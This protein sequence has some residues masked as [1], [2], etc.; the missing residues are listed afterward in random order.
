MFEMLLIAVE[1]QTTCNRYDGDPE[2]GYAARDY[3]PDGRLILNPDRSVPA[4][5]RVVIVPSGPVD[6]LIGPPAEPPVRQP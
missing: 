4:P 6:R 1:G 2:K 3:L 5:D